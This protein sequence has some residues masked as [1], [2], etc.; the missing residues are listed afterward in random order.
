MGTPCNQPRA[1]GRPLWPAVVSSQLVGAAWIWI[2]QHV[3]RR[4]RAMPHLL[5]VG[6]GGTPK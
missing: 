4:R 3:G 6:E 2:G 1:K 5:H